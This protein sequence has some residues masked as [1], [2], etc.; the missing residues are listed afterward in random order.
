VMWLMGAWTLAVFVSGLTVGYRLRRGESPV[1]VPGIT[2]S[3][4][5]V[6]DERMQM[7]PLDREG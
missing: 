2:M 3:S 5:E 6:V 1:S 7:K 4:A